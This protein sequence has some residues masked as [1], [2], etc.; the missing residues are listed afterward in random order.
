MYRALWSWIT[1]VGVTVIVSLLT[2]PD[3]KRSLAGLVYGETVMPSE[4]AVPMYKR[5]LFWAIV[6]AMVFVVANIIF[7]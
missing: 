6:V 3:P 7:W 1:C 5:P 2:K 4:A